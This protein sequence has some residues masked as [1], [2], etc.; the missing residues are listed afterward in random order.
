MIRL[1]NSGEPL[2]KGFNSRGKTNVTFGESL[3]SWGEGGSGGRGEGGRYFRNSFQ[4]IVLSHSIWSHF[5][6]HSF[7][8]HTTYNFRAS[9]VRTRDRDVIP[10]A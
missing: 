5:L 3:F 8:S 7:L 4:A 10:R 1:S 6:A 9:F 2:L